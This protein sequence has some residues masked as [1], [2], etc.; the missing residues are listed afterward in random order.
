MSM[1]GS[2]GTAVGTHQKT[3]QPGTEDRRLGNLGSI[4]NID[5]VT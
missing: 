5:I 2:V 3:G 1:S 4:T